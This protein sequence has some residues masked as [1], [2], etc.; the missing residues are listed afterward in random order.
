MS[1][2]QTEVSGYKLENANMKTE[3][4]KIKQLLNM[5]AKK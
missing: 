5:E 1:S 3:I 2:L 4:E